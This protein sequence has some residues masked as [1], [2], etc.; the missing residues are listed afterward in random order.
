MVPF[1]SA[2]QEILQEAQGEDG[3]LGLEPHLG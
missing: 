2:Q 1:L 3:V